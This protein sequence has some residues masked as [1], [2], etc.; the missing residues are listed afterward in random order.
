[1]RHIIE[2]AIQNRCY[3]RFSYKGIARVVQPTAIGVSPAGNEVLRCFQTEGAHSTKGHEWDLC[4]LSKISGLSVTGKKFD[5]P[6]PGYNRGDK[7]FVK[8]YAE[9]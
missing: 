7:A 4:L 1:M 6:P 9:L 3:L 2:E 5:A 8:I